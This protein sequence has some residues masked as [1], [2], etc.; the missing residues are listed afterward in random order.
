MSGRL[1]RLGRRR[2]VAQIL[3][4]LILDEPHRACGCW[5]GDF[6]GKVIVQA[7][8]HAEAGSYESSSP[9]ARRNA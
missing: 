4:L 9:P 3:T 7:G 1:N 5:L 8:G 6:A 2:D